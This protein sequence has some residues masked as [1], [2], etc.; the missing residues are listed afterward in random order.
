MAKAGKFGLLPDAGVRSTFRL[1]SSTLASTTISLMPLPY[2]ISPSGSGCGRRWRRAI[3]QWRAASVAFL[4]VGMALA[5][6]N[7]PERSL[8]VRTTISG[9]RANLVPVDA[10]ATGPDG[11]VAITQRQD[12]AVKFF[13]PN[14]APLGSAGRRG[15]GPGEFLSLSSAGWSHDSLWT[16][17]SRLRRLTLF[18]KDGKVLRNL[19]VIGFV[20]VS[21]PEP[22]SMPGRVLAVFPDGRLLVDGLAR[23]NGASGEGSPQDRVALIASDSGRVERIVITVPP[24]PGSLVVHTAN[25]LSEVSVPFVT[26]PV[27]TASPDGKRVGVIWLDPL[28]PAPQFHVKVVETSG[29]VVYDRAYSFARVPISKDAIDSSIATRVRRLADDELRR[30][31]ANDLR[32]RIPTHFPAFAA[33]VLGVDGRLWIAPGAG[34]RERQWLVLSPTGDAEFRA[35]LP[36]DV[37]LRSAAADGVWGV[38]DFASGDFTVVHYRVPP[39]RR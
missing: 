19:T 6:S 3:V 20:R 33:A 4:G 7:V 23:R 11:M 24:D 34:A 14:G 1:R 5:Q 12:F 27:L 32:Q 38:R 25:G 9:D 22:E 35:I 18:S 8:V 10:I 2:P 26:R 37:A 29:R 39:M 31:V 21:G 15:S 17:D 28:E 30:R 36:V 13:G 16:W